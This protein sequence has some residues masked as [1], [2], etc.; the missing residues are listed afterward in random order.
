MK[1]LLLL[2]LLSFGLIGSSYACDIICLDK[3]NQSNCFESPRPMKIDNWTCN[4]G[5]T[6]YENG[7]YKEGD[8]SPP[9]EIA[10]F[11]NRKQ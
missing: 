4:E 6:R 2:L 7:C 9:F 1:K 10:T 5:Y 3:K 11:P 8:F